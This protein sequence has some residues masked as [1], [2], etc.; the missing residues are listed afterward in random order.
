MV[1]NVYVLGFFTLFFLT[2]LPTLLQVAVFPVGLA[3]W[4]WLL[5]LNWSQMGWLVL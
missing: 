5:D 4:L 1:Y 2:K 3:P